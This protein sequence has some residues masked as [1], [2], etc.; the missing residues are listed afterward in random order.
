MGPSLGR[1]LWQSE[2]WGTVSICLLR[3]KC[4]FSWARLWDVHSGR[5][6]VGTVVLHVFY[7]QSALRHV[8]TLGTYTLAEGTSGLRFA[9][10]FTAK[11]LVDMGPSLERTLWQSEHRGSVLPGLLRSKWS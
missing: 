7:G 8:P 9:W 6:N 11:V 4:S 3:P 5:V 10:L 2:H 1:T